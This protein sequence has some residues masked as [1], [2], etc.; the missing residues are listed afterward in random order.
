MLINGK[1]GRH[2]DLIALA[3]SAEH[4]LI[5]TLGLPKLGQSTGSSNIQAVAFDPA[6][7]VLPTVAS[8]RSLSP[9]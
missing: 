2:G 9:C 8:S 6:S 5:V 4:K 3:C 7:A 1:P